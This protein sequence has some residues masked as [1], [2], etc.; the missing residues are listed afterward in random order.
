MVTFPI[1]AIS[2]LVILVAVLVMTIPAFRLKQAEFKR[3]GK[4]AEGHYLGLGMA[5]GLLVGLPLG[6]ALGN[7]AFGP[8]LGLPV[9]LAIGSAWEKKHAAELRPMSEAEKKMKTRILILTMA[10]L[11]LGVVAFLA[12]YLMAR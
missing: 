3:T 10:L 2:I 11:M 9:G 7:I 1:I 4:Y 5:L 12:F 6:L 8:G